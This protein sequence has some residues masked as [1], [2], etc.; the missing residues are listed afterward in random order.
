MCYRNYELKIIEGD[1]SIHEFYNFIIKTYG[2]HIKFYDALDENGEPNVDV[3]WENRREDMVEYSK[4]FPETVFCL[5][6]FGY[7]PSES[8][9]EYY[10]NGSF[11]HS[12]LIMEFEKYDENKLETKK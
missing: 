1:T 4:H 6:G 5:Q 11:Q 10:K 2:E 12:V 7:E 9:R 3:D 8:W